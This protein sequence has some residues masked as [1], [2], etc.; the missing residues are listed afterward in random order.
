MKT[1]NRII[2]FTLSFIAF[3][4]FSCNEEIDKAVL[5][6][7]VSPNEMGSL[8][9]SSFVL[10]FENADLDFEDFTWT[11]PDFGFQAS[12]T[13]VL[14]VDVAGF[15]FANA[16]ELGS[17]GELSMTL[18]E[19]D[20]NSAL[21]ALGLNPEESEMLEFRVRSTISDRVNEVVST[22]LEVSLTPFATTFEPIYIIGDAQGW[23]LGKALEMKATGP[24]TYEATGDFVKDGNFRFF[25]TPSWDAEQWGVSFFGAANLPPELGDTGDGDSNFKFLAEDGFYFISVN[26]KTK[27]ITVEEQNFPTNLFIIGDDQGWDLNAALELTHL[28]NGVFEGIG[29]F[30]QD[31]IWRFF[32]SPDWGAKQWNYNTFLDGTIDSKLTGTTEGDANFTFIGETGTYKITV[33]T[34]DLTIVMEATV[35]PTLF[36]IGDDQGW[37]TGA[38]FGLTWLGG[39]KFEGTT[40][41]TTDAIFRFFEKA[42]WGAKQYNYNTFLDGAI[43]E[44]NLSGTT[45]GDANFTFIGTTGTFKIEVDLLNLTLQMSQ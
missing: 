3:G 44:T 1:I 33:S 2:F 10:M 31:N 18:T 21:L 36:I 41:F 9:S 34:V 30:G 14:E 32:E 29:N 16:I 39:S 19:G 5:K 15:A 35:E 11:A 8:S 13:Y 26:M 6:G 42:D 37:D 45:E 40:D 12:A 27:V 22:S 7:T 4:F 38:A 23:D 25:E 24:G 17:T 43:D 20:L 28:G